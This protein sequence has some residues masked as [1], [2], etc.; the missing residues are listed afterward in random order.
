[1]ESHDLEEGLDGRE[2]GCVWGHVVNQRV[3]RGLCGGA[4]ARESR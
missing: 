2:D 3:T 4:V 1:M